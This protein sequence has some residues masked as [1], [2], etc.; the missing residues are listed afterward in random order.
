MVSVSR[1]LGR[2]A[3]G[4]RADLARLAARLDA[5]RPEPS[6]VQ[7]W[8]WRFESSHGRVRLHLRRHADG[9]GVL[10]VNGT[11]AII[12]DAMRTEMAR[13][14]LDN[15]P[16][17]AA[18]VR[19]RTRYGDLRPER[20][21]NAWRETA[22]AMRRLR[23][24]SDGCVVCASGIPQPEPLSV[25]AQAPYKADLALHYACNNRCSHC[26]NEP[27]RRAM[28]AL[29][30]RGWCEVLDR[31]WAIGVPYVIFTGGEPTL[32]ADLSELVAHANSLGMI[33]GLNTNGR[34]LADRALVE[35]LLEAGLDH[36]QI[37]L[38]SHRP[39]VHNR[40]V[41]A[42]AWHETVGGIRASLDTGLHTIT[43][44]TLLR[45]NAPEAREIV[46]FLGDLGL[47]TF[48]MNGIIHAGCGG[49]HPGALELDHLREVVGGVRQAAAEREMRFIWYTVTRHCELS[50]LEE[51]LGLRFCNA[52]EY[53]ICIEPNGDV[54]PCQSYY[55]P[56]GNILRDEWTEIWDGELFSAIRHRREEPAS[57]DLSV[58]CHDC[59]HLRLCG[60]GCP[61]ERRARDNE[62]M[63][64]CLTRPT[65]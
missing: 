56:A 48:A 35:R 47:R 18:L 50:P 44:T 49:D 63:S 60:G 27:G 51:G 2:A 38:A 1:I 33:C 52:A 25:R 12:L 22:R 30:T 7:L 3:D 65:V 41:G 40:M 36:A 39:E 34:W 17:D 58:E 29:D 53:S 26:Y 45:G 16:D 46:H 9:T 43:N 13:L 11:D 6:G 42:E 55:E 20:L 19:L 64:W 54:L 28:L 37:T 8:H 21:E 10:L 24:P 62:V 57:A 15:V 32:R 4:V 61:L 23:R 14:A 31:L 59:E 5:L